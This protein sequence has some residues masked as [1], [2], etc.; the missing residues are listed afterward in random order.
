VDG[1]TAASWD[2]LLDHFEDANI[3]QTWSYGAVRWG[4]RN[5]SHLLLCRGG[6]IVAAVQLRILRVP[7][8]R[9]GIAYAR[10]APL[11]HL[12]G[13]EPD[14]A[15]IAKMLQCMRAEYCDRRGLTLEIIPH[16]FPG[17]T[18]GIALKNALARSAFRTDFRLKNYRTILVDLTRGVDVM[19]ARIRKKRNPD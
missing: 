4:V 14:P 13:E 17:S 2:S 15:V 11:Y 1:Q 9:L 8:L 12:K 10:W 5:L 6:E 16:A 3:Y 18:R 7:F 19:R